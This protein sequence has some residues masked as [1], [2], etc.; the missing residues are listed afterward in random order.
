MNIHI[1]NEE[2][3]SKTGPVKGRVLVEGQGVMERVKK[4]EYIYILV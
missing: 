2:Y 4:G 1:D 3:E